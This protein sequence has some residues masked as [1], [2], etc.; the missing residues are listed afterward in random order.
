[1]NAPRRV[2]KVRTEESA[3]NLRTAIVKGPR[4]SVMRKPAFV[5]LSNQSARII[6][7]KVLELHPYKTAIA[8]GLTL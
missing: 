7:H 6:M 5:E 1:M 4:P 3:E 2:P 8:L